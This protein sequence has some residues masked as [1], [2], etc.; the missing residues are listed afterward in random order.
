MVVHGCDSSILRMEAKGINSLRPA[1]LS[2]LVKL[3][4]HSPSQVGQ[5]G[6]MRKGERTRV[7]KEEVNLYY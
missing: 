3:S 2:C 1:N 4:Q 5:G 7:N 6:G